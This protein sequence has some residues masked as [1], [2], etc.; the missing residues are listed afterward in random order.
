M[1]ED[2]SPYGEVEEISS[3]GRPHVLG[4]QP[5][6][7]QLTPKARIHTQTADPPK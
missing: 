2:P 7:V 6:E 3:A 4:F 1:W 5:E